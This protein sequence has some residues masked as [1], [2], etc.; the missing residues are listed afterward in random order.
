LV[1]TTLRYAYDVVDPRG[2]EELQKLKEPEK[3]E[4]DLAVKIVTDLSGEFDITEY[5]DSYKQKVE[6]LIKKKLQGQTVTPEKP[7]QEE[8]KGLMVALRDT[9][10]QLE[11]Q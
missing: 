3:A 4:L 1:L 10:K 6:E 9:L 2:F 11:K 5:T 7:V 8:V